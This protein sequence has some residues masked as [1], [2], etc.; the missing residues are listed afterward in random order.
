MKAFAR[1]FL[2]LACQCCLVAFCRAEPVMTS[3]L[4]GELKTLPAINVQFDFAAQVCVAVSTIVF[5]A[6]CVVVHL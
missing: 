2:L 5:M 1:V 3:A 4:D 6:N